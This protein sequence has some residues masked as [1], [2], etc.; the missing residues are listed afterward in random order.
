MYPFAVDRSAPCAAVAGGAAIIHVEKEIAAADD[1]LVK[2]LLVKAI[3]RPTFV[4][5]F[6]VTRTVLN[7]TAGCGP[8][9]ELGSRLSRE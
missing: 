7:I 6:Q 9:A 3:R 2:E 1:Q 8:A 5:I 4:E